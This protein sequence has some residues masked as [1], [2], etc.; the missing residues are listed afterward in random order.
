MMTK[1]H[2]ESIAQNIRHQVDRMR[3][4]SWHDHT[5]ELHVLQDLASDLAASF[6]TVNRNFNTQR[7]MTA[8][9]F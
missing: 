8:C 7:F 4:P 9:G 2:F 6:R 5:A 1:Q 3:Q